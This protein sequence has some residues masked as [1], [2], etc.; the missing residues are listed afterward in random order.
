ME[1]NG[2]KVTLSL[3]TNFTEKTGKSLFGNIKE[4]VQG[5][6]NPEET[7]EQVK[8]INQIT[9]GVDGA[10]MNFTVDSRLGFNL[11]DLL[12]EDAE[13]VPHYI[14]KGASKKIQLQVFDGMLK[15]LLKMFQED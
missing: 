5:Y 6:D 11:E 2:N 1:Q 15:S 8:L 3:N 4:R 13:P 14:M 10:S 7:E 12:A 9:D